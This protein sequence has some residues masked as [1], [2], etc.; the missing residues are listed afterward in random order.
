VKRNRTLL[1][2]LTTALLVLGTN[3]GASV[4]GTVS[5]GD[6]RGEVM[7]RYDI[8]RVRY[9]NSADVF[10]VQVKVRNLRNVRNAIV[11]NT[12]TPFMG[13]DQFYIFAKRLP[14]GH[15]VSRLESG[16]SRIPCPRLR[17][18]WNFRADVVRVVVPQRCFGEGHGNQRATVAIGNPMAGDPADF[19]SRTVVPYR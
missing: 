13:Y 15:K 7:A 9:V 5:R 3:G 12:N 1:A 19:V 16:G 11:I 4:A 10:A 14:N 8:T 2:A 17:A 6:A 18:S